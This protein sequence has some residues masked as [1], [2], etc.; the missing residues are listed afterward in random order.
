MIK[1]STPLFLQ[2]TDVF[3]PSF[4]GISSW[5]NRFIHVGL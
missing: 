4:L 3:S 1:S 2:S 5:L